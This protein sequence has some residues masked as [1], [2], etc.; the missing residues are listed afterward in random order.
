MTIIKN[1]KLVYD[2]NRIKVEKLDMSFPDG[3]TET[4]EFFDMDHGCSVVPVDMDGNV[5]LLK[6]YYVGLQKPSFGLVKGMID[7]NE[8]APEAALRELKE[9]AG[10]STKSPLTLL[11]RSYAEP[12][13][14]NANSSIFLAENVIT[15]EKTG[16]DEHHTLE[17]HKIPFQQAVQMILDGEINNTLAISGLLLAKEKLGW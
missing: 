9:E 15:T 7:L 5:Y 13:Y 10:L 2:G 11:T 16:G 14:S 6:E 4:W 8:T 17:V 3:H 12:S 1:R